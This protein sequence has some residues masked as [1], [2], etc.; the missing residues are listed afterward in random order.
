MFFWIL[1]LVIG[2]FLG[3]LNGALLISRGLMHDDVRTHGSGNAGLTNFFRT[4]GGFRSLLVIVIDFGKTLLAC[5]IA[6]LL[7]PEA[8]LRSVVAAGLACILG[9]SFPVLEGF[10]GGKGILCGAAVGLMTDPLIFAII[11]AVFILAVVLTK[12][13]SLGSVLAAAS[14]SVCVLAFYWGDPVTCLLA[15]AAGGF[16]IWRHR[17]NI[18]RLLKGTESKLTFRKK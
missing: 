9:H 1:I 18:G 8:G 16:V 11:M 5:W 13:V 2:Y 3:N 12:Y 10:R 4:Y 15:V 6:G 17:A 14:Y 7:L